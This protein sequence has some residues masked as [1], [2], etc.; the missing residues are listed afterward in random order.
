MI[1]V[2]ICICIPLATGNVY[3][4]LITICVYLGHLSL[5]AAWAICVG[6]LLL[7]TLPSILFY[8]YDKA[9][10]LTV[11]LG[12]GTPFFSFFFFPF[13]LF[14][15]APLLSVTPGS[16][17]TRARAHTHRDTHTH[18]HT[19]THKLFFL[20]PFLPQRSWAQHIRPPPRGSNV[21]R[22]V[23]PCASSWWVA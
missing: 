22:S 17:H 7:G 8:P 3:S 2:Y 1:Y 12:S 9:P 5:P 21:S 19:H 23:L 11:T 16:T 6:A 15:E 4:T 13:L 10:L 20:F 18:T 14:N